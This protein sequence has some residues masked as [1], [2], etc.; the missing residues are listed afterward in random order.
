MHK[1]L[2]YEYASSDQ[3]KMHVVAFQ[4]R[5]DFHNSNPNSMSPCAIKA[6]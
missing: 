2:G 4:R 1:F 3:H 6:T 5:F